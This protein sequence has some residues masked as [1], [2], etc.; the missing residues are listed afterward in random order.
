MTTDVSE[1]GLER[2][3]STALMAA[4]RRCAAVAAFPDRGTQSLHG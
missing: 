2:L 1:W 4:R 3:V